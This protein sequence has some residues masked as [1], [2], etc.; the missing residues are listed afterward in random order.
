[1]DI[2]SID[3]YLQ[4]LVKIVDFILDFANSIAH[5]YWVKYIYIFIWI[6]RFNWYFIILNEK[7]L[8]YWVK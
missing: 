1:M 7:S 3:K 2:F 6:E 4:I 5:S 8:E